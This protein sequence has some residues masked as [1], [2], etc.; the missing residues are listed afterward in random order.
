MQNQPC[1]QP[2]HAAAAAA[3]LLESTL[4]FIPGERVKWRTKCEKLKEEKER[5]ILS[6][7][8]IRLNESLYRQ[9]IYTT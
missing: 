9:T 3:N 1:T 8:N 2:V 6:F 7:C 5:V 4:H